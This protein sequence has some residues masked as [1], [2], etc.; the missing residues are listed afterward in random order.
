M[1]E[2]RVEDWKSP[3]N[4]PTSCPSD[5]MMSPNIWHVNRQPVDYLKIHALGPKCEEALR[6][7]ALPETQMSRSLPCQHELLTAG[8]VTLESLQSQ[9]CAMPPT[10]WSPSWDVRHGLGGAQVAQTNSHRQLHNVRSLTGEAGTK[11]APS[12]SS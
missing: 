7:H 10:L 5:A 9:L 1:D 12:G 3:A 8:V 2:I 11:K 4:S 6:V